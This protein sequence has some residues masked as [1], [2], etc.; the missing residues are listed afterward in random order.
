MKKV[1]AIPAIN[2]KEIIIAKPTPHNIMIII[3]GQD[4]ETGSDIYVNALISEESAVYMAEKL[5]KA[6]RTKK[7][8][9]PF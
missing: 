1:I 6:V 2:D 9:C 8:I 3:Q 5:L 7:T 4:N